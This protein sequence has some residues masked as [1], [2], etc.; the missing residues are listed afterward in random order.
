MTAGSAPKSC[1]EM[2]CSS[3]SKARYCKVFEG[4]RALR[5]ALMPWE[6]VNS[7]ISRP[8]PPR[9]RIKRR[10]T[11][12]VT[13]A[14]GASTV[15]GASLTPPSWNDI[16]TGACGRL[17]SAETGFSQRFCIALLYER[18]SEFVAAGVEGLL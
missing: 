2:G 5:E 18:W 12:S 3:G 13:P 1:A 11:V 14:M 4:L 7:V 9:L 15:A 6:L 8:Q 17:L 16:G 10:N